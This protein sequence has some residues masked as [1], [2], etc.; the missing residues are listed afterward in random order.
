MEKQ[1]T[2]LRNETKV[3]RNKHNKRCPCTINRKEV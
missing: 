1:E 2:R 3:N